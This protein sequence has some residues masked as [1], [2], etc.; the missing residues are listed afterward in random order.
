MQAGNDPGDFTPEQVSAFLTTA[1]DAERERVL[2]AE[3]D[4][5]NR[6]GVLKAYDTP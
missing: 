1:D 5:K 6:A 2:A 3:R 4:G